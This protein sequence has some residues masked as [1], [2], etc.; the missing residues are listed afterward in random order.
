VLAKDLDRDGLPAGST[1]LEYNPHAASAH[2]AQKLV[3]A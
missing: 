3:P 1:G 2:F